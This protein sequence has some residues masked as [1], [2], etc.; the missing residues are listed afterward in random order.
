MTCD[1]TTAPPAL[2]GVDTLKRSDD[3]LGKLTFFEGIAAH[4]KMLPRFVGRYIYGVAAN[5]LLT[6]TEVVYLQKQ[7]CR[8]IP[9]ATTLGKLEM[10]EKNDKSK[11]YGYGKKAARL[12]IGAASALSI[13][14]HV[15]IYADIET[16]YVPSEEWILGWWMEYG[17]APFFG[18]GG[19][20]C[21]PTQ[22]FGFNRGYAAALQSA[23]SRLGVI[24]NQ[25]P[26]LYAAHTNISITPSSPFC[27][28]QHPKHPDGVQ[29][30]QYRGG[31]GPTDYHWD[32][33][34]A[35]TYAYD[36]MW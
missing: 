27:P 16:N 2:W 35:T 26:C 4:E 12:A 21:D 14:G 7:N 20:Y 23:P 32:R 6:P 9:I 25:R 24:A 34:L 3:P 19:F 28:P 33:V 29:I 36:H 5:Q 8:I 11:G 22:T 1:A 10:E 30:W 15:I 31:L 13:P 17:F 18:S